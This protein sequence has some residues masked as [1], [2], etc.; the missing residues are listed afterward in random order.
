MTKILCLAVVLMG[1]GTFAYAESAPVEF[2]YIGVAPDKQN[3]QFSIKVNSDK[4][5]RQVDIGAKYLD[6][7]GKSLMD[8]T[9]AWQNIVKMVKQPI[10]NGKTYKGEGYF[11]PTAAKAEC[12]LLRVIFQD[13]TRW[14]APQ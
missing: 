3:I 5:I 10:E 13:G 7:Q 12:K 4:P 1:L 6:A 2:A 14:S 8:T 11:L 9:I